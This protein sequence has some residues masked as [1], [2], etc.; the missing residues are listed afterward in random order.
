M[1]KPENFS[2]YNK[3]QVILTSGRLVFNA[4]EDSLFLL[5]KKDLAVSTVGDVHINVGLPGSKSS[6]FIVNSNRIQFGLESK[7][8]VAEPVAKAD[9]LL[10]SLKS[11]SKA[12][13]KFTTSLSTVVGT[14]ELAALTQISTSAT[15]LKNELNSFDKTLNSIPSKNTFSI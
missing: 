5:S 10:K 1:T 13:N 2:T 3:N 8:R 15:A 6:I 11:L 9:S 7:G 12:L 4:R 14:V